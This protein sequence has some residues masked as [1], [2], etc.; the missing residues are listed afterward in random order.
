MKYTCTIILAS[1]LCAAAADQALAGSIK[2]RVARRMSQTYP[3]HGDYYDAAWG[4]PVALVVPPTAENQTKMGWGV[5]NTRVVPIEHQFQ[6]NYPGEGIFSRSW[7]Q[8]TPHWPS[9]TDQFGVYY[10]RG[11][12]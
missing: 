8:P 2:D 12:W 9:D 3:W 6:R 1:L 11:P 5:G 4:V 10:I 7:F